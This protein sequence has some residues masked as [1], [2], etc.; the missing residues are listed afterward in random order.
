MTDSSKN[1]MGYVLS[2]VSPPTKERCLTWII[3]IDRSS[4]GGYYTGVAISGSEEDLPP[5]GSDKQ[6][7]T[8]SETENR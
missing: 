5:S 7:T 3:T 6:P 2:A 4:C 1:R 8:S